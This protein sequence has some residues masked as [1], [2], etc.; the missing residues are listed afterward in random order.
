MA[1]TPPRSPFLPLAAACLG[2]A[3][4]LIRSRPES[5]EAASPA[6]QAAAKEARGSGKADKRVESRRRVVPV[7]P[8]VDV[9]AVTTVRQVDWSGEILR[10]ERDGALRPVERATIGLAFHR[11][12]EVVASHEVNASNGRW[13]LDFRELP[14]LF[15][16]VT[17]EDAT[18]D[19]SPC[20]I[21]STKRWELESIGQERLILLRRPTRSLLHVVS[22]ATGQPLEKV[23]IASGSRTGVTLWRDP[24]PGPSLSSPVVLNELPWTR[25]RRTICVGAPGHVWTNVEVDIGDG[26]DKTVELKPAAT[27]VVSVP[28]V[29]AERAGDIRLSLG[30]VL[31]V[32]TGESWNS[33][34]MCFEGRLAELG[35]RPPVV[36]L[37][38]RV[39]LGEYTLAAEFEPGC[40]CEKL[41]LV[42]ER[43]SIERAE[44]VRCELT[45]GTSVAPLTCSVTGR[46]RVPVRRGSLHTPDVRRVD[47]AVADLKSGSWLPVE[48]VSDDGRERIYEWTATDFC[49]GTY[50]LDWSGLGFVARFEVPHAREHKVELVV[51]SPVELIVRLVDADTGVPIE[52]EELHWSPVLSLQ[53]ER[54]FASNRLS[55][56]LD[57]GLGGYRIRSV[58]PCVRFS[59][60]GV[61]EAGYRWPD[62]EPLVSADSGAVVLS[63]ER[64]T[65]VRVVFEREGKPVGDWSRWDVKVRNAQGEDCDGF[66]WNGPDFEAQELPGGGRYSIQ[67][68]SSGHGEPL[69]PIAFD[70][71][72]GESVTIRVELP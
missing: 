36:E 51:P 3:L 32:E 50:E 54:E 10:Q 60:F 7:S 35:F 62:E 52:M 72:D 22:A 2:M 66:S 64:T 11:G 25:G 20:E 6:P 42:S 70:V 63:L 31:R 43:L 37:N 26:Q 61:K 41:Q 15:D 40:G 19:G 57:P 4:V 68:S 48:L 21:A 8:E 14:P 53:R 27:L 65:S 24:W 67:V 55:V 49:P 56:P 1:L 47:E 23:E 46:I 9:T 28:G 44:T 39:P 12:D 58:S 59:G 34:R 18:L 45:L 71:A 38:L 29:P 30:A 5:F 69:A 16:F 17:L 13:S 33:P